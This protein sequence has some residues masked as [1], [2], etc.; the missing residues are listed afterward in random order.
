MEVPVGALIVDPIS[1]EIVARAHNVSEHGKDAVAHAE[2]EVMRKACR[3]LKQKTAVG[4]GNV[5]DAGTLHDVRGTALMRVAKIYFGAADAKGGGGQRG[6]VLR[7]ADLVITGRSSKA[8][9]CKM[10]RRSC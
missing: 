1:G 8:E 9:F 10:R 4:V 7:G 5:C 6:F 3:R 2:I